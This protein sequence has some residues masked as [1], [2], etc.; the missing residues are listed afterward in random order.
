MVLPTDGALS[1][2]VGTVLSTVNVPL[3]PA[4]GA[5]FPTVST[6]VPAASEIPS[7]PLPV[8]PL[9]V[10][11]RVAPD[12]VTPTVPFAVPVLFNVMF[13][14]ASVLALKFASAYVTV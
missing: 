5:T 9:I 2:T 4:A 13:P 6:A 14:T 3:G 8:I 10:T 12:P 1:V 11:V 7:V